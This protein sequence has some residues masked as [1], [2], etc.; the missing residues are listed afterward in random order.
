MEVDTATSG[1]Q[2]PVKHTLP[3]LE[4]YCY[5]LVLIFLIDQ[6]Y[7]NEVFNS[8]CLHQVLADFYLQLS[9]FI[10]SLSSMYCFFAS[11]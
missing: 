2:S 3:E 8:A 5:L 9:M 7:Y 4:M 11:G 1:I 10:I 6:K